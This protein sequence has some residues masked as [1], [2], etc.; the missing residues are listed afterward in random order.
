[1]GKYFKDRCCPKISLRDN[2][3]CLGI[4]RLNFDM[5]DLP[6][7]PSILARRFVPLA[8]VLIGISGCGGGGGSASVVAVSDSYV[9]NNPGDPLNVGAPGVLQNDS[10]SGL[11]AQLISGPV[12]MTLNSDGSFSI[13]NGATPTSFSYRALNGTGSATA[14]A[15]I[16]I[17][18]PPV[19]N[20]ACKT[21]GRGIAASDFLSA[22][23]PEG[24]ALTYALASG[25]TSGLSDGKKGNVT[26]NS[27]TGQF[28]YTPC[29]APGT[30]S[31]IPASSGAGFQGVDKFT[32]RV[33][34]PLLKT[35]TGVVTVL[36]DGAVRIMP[37]GDSITF[38]VYT[39]TSPPDAEAIGYRRQLYNDLEA[40]SPA[41]AVN[42]V[43]G[44]SNGLSASPPIV[45]PDHEGHPGFCAGP[46]GCSNGNI[47]D[48]VI[49]WLNANP[50]DVIL[51]HIGTNN[52]NNTSEADISTI[53]NRVNTWATANYPTTVFVA[54][55][56][57]TVDGSFDVN[58]FNNNVSS[59][60]TDRSNVKVLMVNQQ[61]G[62]GINNG[63]NTANPLFMDDNL[64]PNQSGYNKMA[65]KWESD[66][67][68]S[69]V[70]PSCPP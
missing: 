2:L 30:P 40:L 1:M 20:N 55:I 68:A 29:S 14:N 15:I 57:P 67:V 60:A 50:A 11:T 42:F 45:D 21:T 52:F 61:T 39:V 59:I 7:L 36:I 46:T 41:Y 32:F 69:G 43:G 47:T 64:H 27:A 54:R 26:I 66:L 4:N 3:S 31:C 25:G 49:S 28:T 56:I 33:T 18:Q 44:L 51:L 23:D 37:L 65:D 53:L 8:L 6:T 22:T 16:N 19:A 48:N 58:S 17:N 62:A 24:A 38:G 10:G 13:P 35:S 63:I 34:D 12:G 70:L 9:V 5:R